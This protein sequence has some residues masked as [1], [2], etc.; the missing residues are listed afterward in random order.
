MVPRAFVLHLA[1]A[2]KRRANARDLLETCGLNGEIWPAVD[3]AAVSARDLDA[4][5][6][7]H[8]FDPP[9]PFG[10]R[11]GEI[12][13][14]L[15]HRQIWA[16]MQARDE[17]A[18]LIIEDDAAL[19]PALFSDALSLALTHVEKLG[20][21][22]FQTRP[23]HGARTLI[24]TAGRCALTVPRYAGLR[25]TA[26]I[27]SRAAAARL[28]ELSE[29]FDRP[30]DTFVQSHWHTGLR[31]AMIYPSGVSDIADRL[32]GSTIQSSNRPVLEK[33]RREVQRTLYRRQAVLF[34]R[35]SGAHPQGG[36]DG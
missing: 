11:T 24:D 3:G 28:L 13:C 19:D 33:L 8:I 30:V 17:D 23:A 15:S 1:R 29:I 20:Y 34:S 9:Y 35:S 36:M 2:E 18:A 32:D 31:P 27:V 5:V 22:Q 12:G 14:F 25:T 26:Q 7:T 4:T 16:E 10:L 6:G 21:I